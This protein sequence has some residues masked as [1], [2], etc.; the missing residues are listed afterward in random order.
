M[1]GRLNALPAVR[2]STP[3]PVAICPPLPSLLRCDCPGFFLYA[4]AVQT[5]CTHYIFSSGPRRVLIIF[6]RRTLCYLSPWHLQ[7]W[8]TGACPQS[9]DWWDYTLPCF[10]AFPCPLHWLAVQRWSCVC[11]IRHNLYLF[12]IPSGECMLIFR[13]SAAFSVEIQFQPSR[14]W[15][16]LKLLLS[17]L[18]SCQQLPWEV[19]GHVGF[20]QLLQSLSVWSGFQAP[21]ICYK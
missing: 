20:L 6:L 14:R 3:S 21:M 5:S 17:F 2:P 19:W 16:M 12:F 11:S 15:K 9:I 7:C 10:I 1:S 18:P 8:A 4:T 13:G